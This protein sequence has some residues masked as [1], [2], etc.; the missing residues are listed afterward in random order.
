[1]TTVA[2]QARKAG[3]QRRASLEAALVEAEGVSYKSGTF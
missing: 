1:M 3:E 2:K